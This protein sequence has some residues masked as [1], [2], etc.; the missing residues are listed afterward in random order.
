MTHSSEPSTRAR[1]RASRRRSRGPWG[2]LREVALILVSAL[3]I[4]FL[5]KTFLVR[6]FYIPSESMEQTLMINDRIMVNVLQPKVFPLS[7]GDVI[8]FSD[9]GNWLGEVPVDKEPWSLA[10][11]IG[12]LFQTIGLGADDGTQHLVKRIIGL[13]GDHVVCSAV[14]RPL[15]VNGVALNET[16]YLAPG[17]TSCS[18]GRL[19]NI[20]VPKDSLWVMG[21]NRQHSA[22]SSAHQ[23]LPGG[24]SVPISDVVG[25]AFAITWPSSR[26]TGIGDHSE[27]FANVPSA[28]AQSSHGD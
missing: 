25:R 7:R 5:I 20:T 23:D 6:S 17:A 28:S 21:D 12:D 4:S 10:T 26:W 19:F 11:G 27:V 1:T 16:P 13:P 9:P 24:G 15:T 22:D 8:V 3:L 18:A 14:D 2:F